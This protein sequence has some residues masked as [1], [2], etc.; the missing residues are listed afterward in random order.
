LAPAV[1]LV[2]RRA[3]AGSSA[4]AT[5]LGG[6][7][8]AV[9]ELC[10]RLGGIPRAL[11]FAAE[12]LRTI[13]IRS[14]L[15]SGPALGALRTSDHSLLPHQRSLTGSI[16]WSID[17]LSDDHRRLL[18]RIAGLSTI[19]FA[20]DQVVDAADPPHVAMDS[21]LCLFS[22]LVDNA[23]V[24]PSGGGLYEYRLMPYVREVICAEEMPQHAYA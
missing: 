13:P 21:A 7:I 16:R 23:L 6:D 19:R 8:P 20:L 1:E 22:D 3:S 4:A 24:T 11:E 14:L 18:R 9:A 5:D 12:R 2:L 10:R 17:L 15:A